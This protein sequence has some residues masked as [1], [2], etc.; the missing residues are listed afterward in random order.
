MFQ[1]LINYLIDRFTA[2]GR[3]VAI[4]QELRKAFDLLLQRK[5]EEP[6]LDLSGQMVV[7]LAC[8]LLDTN[9]QYY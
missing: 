7:T 2:A 3:I 8:E 4:V 1:Y 9:A 5:F 6:E